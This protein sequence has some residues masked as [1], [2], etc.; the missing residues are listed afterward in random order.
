MSTVTYTK[1]LPTPAE[2]LNELGFTQFEMLLNAY[3]PIYRQAVC[4]TVNHLLSGE[5][6]NKSQC[7]THLQQIYRINKRHAN[8]VI[9]DALGKVSSAKESR[10]NHIK[11]LQGKLK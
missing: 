4:E 2:E 1:G 5:T 11:Q 7:N 10:Q 8:G 6:F 3:A 9:A